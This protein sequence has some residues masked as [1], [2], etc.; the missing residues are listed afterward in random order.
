MY[1]MLA[2]SA[3]GGRPVRGV[4]IVVA[5]AIL[6]A[7]ATFIGLLLYKLLYPHALCTLSV[8]A[9]YKVEPTSYGYAVILEARTGSTCRL[10][11][12]HYRFTVVTGS[13]NYSVDADGGPSIARVV[14][15]PDEP[16]MVIVNA[17]TS[18]GWSEGV[19][20]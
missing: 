19:A 18:W 10:T 12:V 15:L 4:S 5:V 3:V 16:L 17:S 2:G 8:T 13:G 20:R 11:Q 1:T 9:D 14:M 7:V 6:L